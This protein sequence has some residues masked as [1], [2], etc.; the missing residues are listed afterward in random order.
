MLIYCST[1]LSIAAF[2]KVFPIFIQ[3]YYSSNVA[4]FIHLYLFIYIYS[5]IFI[6]LYLFIFIY[7]FIYIYSFIF[8]H[9]YLFIY[10]YLFIFVHLS[11]EAA[12]FH[13]EGK[14]VNILTIAK[15]KK[16]LIV[17]NADLL[18]NRSYGKYR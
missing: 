17:I 3:L 18:R 9:L 2:M 4:V 1:R 12:I 10:I 5:F 14:I 8:I 15:S 13:N 16:L 7:L 6:H 11:N